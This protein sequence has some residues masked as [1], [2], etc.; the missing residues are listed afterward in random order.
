[1]TPCGQI[2]SVKYHA[3]M[4]SSS[5]I[6]VHVPVDEAEF[7]PLTLSPRQVMHGAAEQSPLN[8][9]VSLAPPRVV[10]LDSDT[11]RNIAGDLVA[12]HAGSNA[13]P[14]RF[15]LLTI[16]V[17]FHHIPDEPVAQ[18]TVGIQLVKEPRNG[19]PEPVA[20]AMIPGLAVRAVKRSSTIRLGADLQM[21][22]SEVGRS[23]EYESGEP[24]L[25]AHQP[26]RS[27]PVWFFNRTRH[28]ELVGPH[29]LMTVVAM[30]P[31]SRCTAL[32]SLTASI[33]RRRAGLVGYEAQ[34]PPDFRLVN[35][36]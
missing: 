10:T 11:I 16:D 36:V 5:S 3:A 24:Y 7:V 21:I 1:M 30:P 31:A 6:F 12:L 13:E 19:G 34:L 8:D 14:L 17:S 23:V 9:R 22:N 27:D 15:C 32:I 2:A 18:A 33:R 20:I 35:L 29:Q 26:G 25:Q 28:Q 4:D